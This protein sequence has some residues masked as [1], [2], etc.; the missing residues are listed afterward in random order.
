MPDW[1]SVVGISTTICVALGGEIPPTEVQS[2]KNLVAQ[3]PHTQLEVWIGCHAHLNFSGMV[4]PSCG[5]HA[6]VAQFLLT[7]FDSMDSMAALHTKQHNSK[8]GQV[9]MVAL[10]LLHPQIDSRQMYGLIETAIITS[11]HG[12]NVKFFLLVLNWK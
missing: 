4:F 9:T 3:F 11:V 5:N 12:C 1:F 6:S 10:L 8:S 7:R 2:F